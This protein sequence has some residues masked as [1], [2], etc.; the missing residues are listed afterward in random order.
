MCNIA[1]YN[2]NENAA[3]LL[4]E[5]MKKQEGFGGGYYSGITTLH[6]GMIYHAKVVGNVT[7]L[8]KETNAEDFPG[9]ISIAHSRPKLGGGT[10][11]GHPFETIFPHLKR[12]WRSMK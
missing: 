7:A 6:E 5:M 11:W 2:G 12:I 3:D 9:T 10:E 4:L 8:C 1:G